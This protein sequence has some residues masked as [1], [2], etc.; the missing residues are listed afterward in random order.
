MPIVTVGKEL[1]IDSV[2]GFLYWN[3]G[4]AIECSRLNGENR[5]PYDPADIYKQQGDNTMFFNLKL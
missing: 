2:G 1:K 4:H 3:T 5:I